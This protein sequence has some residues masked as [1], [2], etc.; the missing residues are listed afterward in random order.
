MLP[1]C[2]TNTAA[3]G[4]DRYAGPFSLYR[5]FLSNIIIYKRARH[6]KS[7][8]Y[9]VGTEIYY[10]FDSLYIDLDIDRD[11]IDTGSHR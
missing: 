1:N 4:Q 9:L 7:R 2:P 5:R 8:P 10:P 11:R 6:D 3:S